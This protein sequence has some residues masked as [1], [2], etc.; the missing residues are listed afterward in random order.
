MKDISASLMNTSLCSN[1]FPTTY[2]TCRGPFFSAST[3]LKRRGGGGRDGGKLQRCLAYLASRRWP[4]WRHGRG[5]ALCVTACP[6]SRHHLPGISTFGVTRSANARCVKALL[7][8]AWHGRGEARGGWRRHSPIAGVASAP[9]I[10]AAR[11]AHGRRFA[12]AE[13]SGE[14][15]GIRGVLRLRS[16]LLIAPKARCGVAALRPRLISPRQSGAVALPARRVLLRTC[17]YL[18]A[19]TWRLPFLLHATTPVSSLRRRF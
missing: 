7:P 17:L 3:Y 10:Y 12:A 14:R 5:A 18:L 11:R 9:S 13:R 8:L 4:G 16:L 15:T 2:G 6:K 1:L 19:Q